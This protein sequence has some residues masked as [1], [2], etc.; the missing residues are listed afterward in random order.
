MKTSM[1]LVAGNDPRFSAVAAEA[2]QVAYPGIAITTIGSLKDAVGDGTAEGPEFLVL[3]DGDEAKIREAALVLD[4]QKLPR[5]AVVAPGESNSGIP[6]ELVPAADWNR[7]SLARAFRD[8]LAYQVT[9][10][11]RMRLRGD[12]LTIG[13]RIAHDMRTP[14]SG[15]ISSTEVVDACGPAR[16]GEKSLTQPIIESAND[17][18]KIIS[19]LSLV[20]KASARP[21]SRQPFNMTVPV[22]RALEKLEMRI[23][24][25]G[26]TVSRP[27]NWPNVT[28]EPAYAE[29]IWV[30][31]LDNAIR[32][33]GKAPKVEVGWE[34][35]ANGNKF[36]V[37]DQGPGIL[38]EKRRFL[39]YPFH[40]LHEPNAPKGLGLPIVDRLAR[41]QGGRCGYEPATP[42][43]ASFSFTLPQ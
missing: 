1:L 13:I 16:P 19:Q 17:L 39:F 20:T 18:V 42:S 11:E 3:C 29:A 8:A 34:T 12:L 25:K 24:E 4:A 33:S 41:L 9:Q 31:L 21:D 23:R 38:A 14:V 37:R 43:G 5:F 40:C 28:G 7:S 2:A 15:I 36:W 32:H 26:A 30:G 22:G 6:A 35:V 10:R 27:Q